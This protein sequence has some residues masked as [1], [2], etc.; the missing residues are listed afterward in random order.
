MMPRNTGRYGQGT[1]TDRGHAEGRKPKHTYGQRL[2]QKEKLRNKEYQA[3]G[4]VWRKVFTE[5]VFQL[6]HLATQEVRRMLFHGVPIP[7]RDETVI[8]AA[9]ADTLCHGNFKFAGFSPNATQV[10]ENILATWS[11][12]R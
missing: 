8:T 1:S 3:H 9:E 5:D 7:M 12:A 11:S 2:A 4:A 6:H 10:S